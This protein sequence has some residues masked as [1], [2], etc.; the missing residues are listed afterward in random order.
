MLNKA[1]HFFLRA[2]SV[3]F[4][5]NL[6]SHFTVHKTAISSSIYDADSIYFTVKKE[7]MRSCFAF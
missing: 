2:Y 3:L 4:I 6:R 1:S 7:Q 5:V